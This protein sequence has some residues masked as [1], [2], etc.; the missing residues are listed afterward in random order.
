LE[1]LHNF[2]Q[3]AGYLKKTD[4]NLQTSMQLPQP[5]H[6]SSTIKYGERGVSNNGI[7][8][9]LFGAGGT[10]RAFFRINVKSSK[11]TAN[12]SFATPIKDVLLKLVSKSF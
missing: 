6:L 8:W 2:Y 1:I 5:V 7:S 4:A 3:N 9:A 12:T 11:V 10:A